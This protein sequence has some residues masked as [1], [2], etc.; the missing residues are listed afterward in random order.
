MRKRALKCTALCVGFL[1][2]AMLQG[3]LPNFESYRIGAL[4]LF[5]YVNSTLCD[6]SYLGNYMLST[7]YLILCFFMIYY[8]LGKER[9]LQLL[10]ES[11]TVYYTRRYRQIVMISFGFAFIMNCLNFGF[12]LMTG[13]GPILMRPVYIVLFIFQIVVVM[14]LYATI[15]LLYEILAI[16]FGELLG[17]FLAISGSIAFLFIMENTLTVRNIMRYMS[18]YNGYIMTYLFKQLYVKNYAFSKQCVFVLVLLG[19]MMGMKILYLESYERKD[20]LK[21]E[22]R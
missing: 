20:Y 18:C 17:M 6:A 13:A 12:L 15:Y 4:D 1:L 7:F 5:E 9:V 21:N 10:R 22:K 3:Y 2:A 16:R 8:I 11:K 19:I 14:S